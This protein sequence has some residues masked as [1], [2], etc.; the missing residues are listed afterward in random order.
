MK[1]FSKAWMNNTARD[2]VQYGECNVCAVDWSALAGKTW[3]DGFNYATVAT[4]HTK[5]VAHV[6]IRFIKFLIDKQGL[7]ISDISIAGHRYA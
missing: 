3:T 1:L 2:W 5:Q 7:K 4:K 6:I